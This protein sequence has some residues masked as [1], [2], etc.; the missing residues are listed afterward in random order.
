MD[1]KNSFLLPATA[2]FNRQYQ[3][4]KVIN[5]LKSAK[6]LATDK[7][8]PRLRAACTEMESLFI[9]YLF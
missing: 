1:D 2:H 3:N 5:A 9:K 6:N 4:Q 8:D 7:A